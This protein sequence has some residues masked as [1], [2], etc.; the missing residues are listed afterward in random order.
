MGE[1]EALEVLFERPAM[2]KV[3][4]W[5]EQPTT[6]GWGVES[7]SQGFKSISAED[8]LALRDGKAA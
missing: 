1:T 5:P 8:H 7:R 6:G 2:G 3:T 4:K